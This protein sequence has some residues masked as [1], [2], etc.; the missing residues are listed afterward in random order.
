M[1]CQN[2]SHGLYENYNFGFHPPAKLT[3]T[4]CSTPGKSNASE[5]CLKASAVQSI[6]HYVH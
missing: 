6:V 3:G 5:K 4:Q 1:S 2:W